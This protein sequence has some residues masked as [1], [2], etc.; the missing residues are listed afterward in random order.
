MTC[1]RKAVAA[2]TAGQARWAIGWFFFVSG[3]GFA[4]WASRIPTI[5]RQLGLN[6]AELGGV[7]LAMPAGLL[8][9]LPVTGPLLRRFSSRQVMLVGALL[10]N[11]VTNS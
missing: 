4:T 5:Q 11:R 6:E 3:F 1:M 8:L 10:Y 9:T 7:L 2:P